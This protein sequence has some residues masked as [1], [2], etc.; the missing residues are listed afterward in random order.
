MRSNDTTLMQ[1]QSGRMVPLICEISLEDDN[2]LYFVATP[3]L[4]LQKALWDTVAGVTVGLTVM[5]QV[6]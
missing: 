5:P 2:Q 1:I 4:Q 3:F 6:I